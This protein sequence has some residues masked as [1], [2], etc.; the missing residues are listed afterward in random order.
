[1]VLTF[2]SHLTFQFDLL[3]QSDLLLQWRLCFLLGQSDLLG[4]V[5]EDLYFPWVQLTPSDLWFQYFQSCRLL[6][7]FQL[8]PLD[9]LDPMDPIFL[10]NLPLLVQLLPTIL[11]VQ[12]YQS[13]YLQVE[14][15]QSQSVQEHHLLSDPYFQSILF[16]Q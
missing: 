8:D 11:S 12:C 3:L 5:G 1:M 16:H 2:Q 14:S 10:S 15:G 6:Q 13:G 9:P 4:Q 7:C